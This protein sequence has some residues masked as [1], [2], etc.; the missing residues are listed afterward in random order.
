MTQKHGQ[1]SRAALAALA[2]VLPP[3]LHRISRAATRPGALHLVIHHAAGRAGGACQ[4]A[5]HLKI[6][7]GPFDGVLRGLGWG[8]PG[9][10]IGW[11]GWVGRR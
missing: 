10:W 11:A 4:G 7:Q 5:V 6:G 1:G 2:S 9:G 3:R 8:H